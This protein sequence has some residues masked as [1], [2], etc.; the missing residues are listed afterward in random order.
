MGR[1]LFCVTSSSKC[2][3]EFSSRSLEHPEQLGCSALCST[4][5]EVE[6]CSLKLENAVSFFLSNTYTPQRSPLSDPCN[7]HL[8]AEQ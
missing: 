8:R 7:F 1:I 4:V 5:L 2:L 3:T 6:D